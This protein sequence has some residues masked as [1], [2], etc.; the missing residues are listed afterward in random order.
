MFGRARAREAGRRTRP[1]S[2]RRSPTS[3]RPPP[4]PASTSRSP[5]MAQWRPFDRRAPVLIARIKPLTMEWSPFSRDPFSR[6]IQDDSPAEDRGEQRL[7]SCARSTRGTMCFETRQTRREGWLLQRVWRQKSGLKTSLG[8]S[9]F[10]R[11]RGERVRDSAHGAIRA[12]PALNLFGTAPLHPSVTV[13]MDR[14]RTLVARVMGME[15][16]S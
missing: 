9:P 2:I 4:R 10:S 16:T 12:W 15:L 13:D 7:D 5:M 1:C 11:I 3:R 6:T 14:V 8:R